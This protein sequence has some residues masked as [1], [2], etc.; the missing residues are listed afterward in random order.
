MYCKTLS[1]VGIYPS[2]FEASLHWYTSVLGLKEAF[3]LYDKEDASRVNLIYL[4]LGPRTFIEIFNQPQRAIRGAIHFSIEVENIEE[5]VAE[6]LPRLPVESVKNPQII[7]GRD[8]SRIFNFFDPDGN[9]IELQQFP[10]ES[11]QAKSLA[12][13]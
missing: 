13:L 2:D 11:Q 4:H 3:R 12:S 6:L 5:S 9:R 10:P 1:H 8:G 7:T